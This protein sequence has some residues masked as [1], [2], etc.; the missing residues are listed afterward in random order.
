MSLVFAVLTLSPN[1]Y[2]IN[3]NSSSASKETFE[4]IVSKKHGML[5]VSEAF[6]T[7]PN[8]RFIDVNDSVIWKALELI[9]G[10]KFLPRDGIHAAT[11]LIAGADSIYSED[12]D[13]DRIK[14]L[15]RK[16]KD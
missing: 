6:L 10:Y 11:A 15:K 12:V 4:E 9:R 7:M 8:M 16:W 13:F 14:G 2:K 3:I 1:A 5:K